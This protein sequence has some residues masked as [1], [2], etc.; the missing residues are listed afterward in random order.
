MP[1]IYLSNWS[2]HASPGHHG[3][4]RKFSIMACPRSWEHG[5]G[6]VPALTPKVA[7]LVAMRDRK[8][9][10]SEYKKRFLA[11]ISHDVLSP[12]TLMVWLPVEGTEMPQDAL[13]EDGDTLC[14]ACGRGDAAAGMCHRTWAAKLLDQA[15]WKVILDGV[16]WDVR[17]GEPLPPPPDTILDLFGGHDE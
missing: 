4:G 17:N 12:G 11:S 15:G 1:T 5:E 14:C 8:I 9:K 10:F 16:S 6:F 2:S 3:P 13:I 7:D